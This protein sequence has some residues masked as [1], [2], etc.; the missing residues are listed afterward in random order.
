MRTSWTSAVFAVVV[1][2]A[3]C[4]CLAQALDFYKNLPA[5]HMNDEDRRVARSAIATALEN[6]KDGTT[7][8]WEN[9][10]TGASGSV[11]PKK[12]FSR[13]GMRCRNAEFFVSAG[14]RENVSTWNVCKTD[15]GW[16]VVDD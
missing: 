15:Q 11:M 2:G 1:A 8:R 4:P 6:A 3:S 10:G 7:H 9:R 12:S 5:S 14:G 13:N 16:K